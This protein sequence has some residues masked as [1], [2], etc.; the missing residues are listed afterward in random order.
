MSRELRHAL[1]VLA[2]RPP[3]ASLTCG[4]VFRWAAEA[5]LPQAAADRVDD[6]TAGVLL[7]SAAARSLA[8]LRRRANRHSE[9]V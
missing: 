8:G 7:R 4:D 1:V 2:G 6:L 5:G 3:T 9:G